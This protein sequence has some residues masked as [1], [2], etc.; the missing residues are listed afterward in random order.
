MVLKRILVTALGAL[1]LSALATGPTFA[2]QVPAPDFFGDQIV[3]SSANAAAVVPDPLAGTGANMMG[4][5]LLEQALRGATGMGDPQTVA[6]ALG[7]TQDSL[8]FVIDPTEANCGRGDGTEFATTDA[9]YELASGYT[10]ALTQF[11]AVLRE[12][13]SVRTAQ[14]A[15]KDAIEGGIESA[16]LSAR[17]GL[18]E[19]QADLATEQAKLNAIGA[20]PIYQ[21]GI[22]EWRAEVR[23]DAAVADWDAA[24]PE[25]VRAQTSLRAAEYG[26]YV[27]LPGQNLLTALT[28]ADGNL[29][30]GAIAAYI[31]EAT[32]GATDGFDENQDLIIPD[33]DEDGVP[34]VT[35]T[36]VSDVMDNSAAADR[37]VAALKEAIADTD[38]GVQR[39]RLGEALR[40][41]EDEQLHLN[42]Y[43]RR[44]L[45]DNTELRDF[46]A[47]SE[48]DPTHPDYELDS[49]RVRN[50][51]YEGALG[52]RDEAEGELRDAVAARVAA[53]KGV[54]DAFQGPGSYYDQYV[55]RHTYLTSQ[56]QKVVDDAT[57]DG[58]TPTKTESD[59]LAAA[60]K[61]RDEATAARDRYQAMVADSDNP[62]VNLIG[63]LLVPD[64]QN[65]DDDGQAVVDAVSD[66]YEVAKSASD[67]ANRVA[68]EVSGLT[69]EGGAVATNAANIAENT[70]AIGILDGRVTKN[71]DDI[72]SNT[73]MIGE[74]R[75]MIVTNAGNIATNSMNIMENRGMIETNEAGIT[76]NAG[77]ISENRG[78][79]ETNSAGI[80][81]NADA[82]AANMNSIGSNSSAISDNRNMIGE[83]SDDLDVVRAGVAASMALAGMPAI[84]GRGISIGVGSFDGESAFAVGFQIQG[85]MA[86]FKVGVTSASGA[87]GAS[88]G[89]GFQF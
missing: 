33:A 52:E 45:N 70:E 61:A 27:V 55:N 53:T 29:Q 40:R 58:R 83:L 54:Q 4:P 10:Q 47:D 84:N 59:A 56:A 5:S 31:G 21:A 62:A 41:A 22:R 67:T 69:G 49:I 39:T 3:C 44:A 85:E 48:T 32:N 13:N 26:D 78:M 76:M 19:A 12:E 1:G 71:E 37:A 18:E 87:T 11:E 7:A 86:S 6:S 38:D 73:M 75:D 88:A 68:D 80:S 25:V 36:A 20:G 60:Q 63:D 2:Q 14:A 35:T 82:I 23:V 28:D 77:A 72:A 89:V 42:E 66:T 64:G 81:S 9:N 15:L 8:D 51:D 79:I 30:R 50:G 43:L 57:A 24:V 17:E 74:N 65:A 16:I 46:V 34:D